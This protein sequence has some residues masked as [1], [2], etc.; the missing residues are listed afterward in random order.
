[1]PRLPD[2]PWTAPVIGADPGVVVVTALHL[3]RFRD[4]PAFLRVSLAIARQTRRSPGARS[5][6]LR[7]QPLA[8]RFTTVSWW[9]DAAAVRAFAA[10]EPHRSALRTWRPRLTAFDYT[11]HAGTAGR[12][13]TVDAALATAQADKARPGRQPDA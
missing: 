2:L 10:A 3:R 11:E 6:R 13:P 7:A 5:L 12:V 8:R 9:D 4:V 1:M